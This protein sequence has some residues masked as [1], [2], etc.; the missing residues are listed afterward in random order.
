[1][2]LL[3]HGH[4]LLK[5]LHE[6]SHTMPNNEQD[7]IFMNKILKQSINDITT[8]KYSMNNQIELRD[9]WKLKCPWKCV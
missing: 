2:L 7:L 8:M 9:K 4:A 3:Y 1:V 6:I 5:F